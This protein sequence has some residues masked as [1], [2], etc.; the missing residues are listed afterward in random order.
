M[1]VKIKSR[2]RIMNILEAVDR[3]VCLQKVIGQC[4]D[5][6]SVI[7]GSRKGVKEKIKEKISTARFIHCFAYKLNLIIDKMEQNAS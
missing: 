7:S 3:F 6:A 4:Y 2:D 1:H 5:G